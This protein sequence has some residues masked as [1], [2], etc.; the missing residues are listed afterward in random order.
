MA[1]SQAGQGPAWQPFGYAPILPKSI[2]RNR[3]GDAA[4]VTL[5]LDNVTSM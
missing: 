5:A 3:G 4:G 2:V 1:E